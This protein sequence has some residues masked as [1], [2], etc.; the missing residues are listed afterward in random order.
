[1]SVCSEHREIHKD[2]TGKLTSN[3]GLRGA[4]YKEARESFDAA[5]GW[6]VAMMLEEMFLLQ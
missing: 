5:A 4:E 2:H 3:D 1:M 6:R